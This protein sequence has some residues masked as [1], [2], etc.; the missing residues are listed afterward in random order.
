MIPTYNICI[1]TSIINGIA[2]RAHIYIHKYVN[3]AV[4][5]LHI[6]V[7]IYMTVD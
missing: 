5:K 2:T 4:C 1:C 6:Y 7:Y 3:K